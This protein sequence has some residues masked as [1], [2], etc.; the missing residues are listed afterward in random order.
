[1]YLEVNPNYVILNL[2]FVK[3]QKQNKSKTKQNKTK[4][5]KED[6]LLR[7]HNWVHLPI[8]HSVLLP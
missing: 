4:K 8:D 6:F 1:M 7:G 2:P 5:K 3:K